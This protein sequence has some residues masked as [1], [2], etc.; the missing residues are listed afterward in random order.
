MDQAGGEHDA[1]GL[2]RQGGVPPHVRLRGH[3]SG[4]VPSPL[5][6]S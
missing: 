2:P 1:G 6:A 5:K 3:P 4:A